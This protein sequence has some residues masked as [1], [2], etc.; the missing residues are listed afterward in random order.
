MHKDHVMKKSTIK[1]LI[2]LCKKHMNILRI[3]N[4]Q[5]FSNKHIK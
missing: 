1:D 2:R 4:K 3:K 5:I